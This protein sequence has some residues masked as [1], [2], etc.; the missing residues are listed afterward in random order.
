M[1]SLEHV[2]KGKKS[3]TRQILAPAVSRAIQLL[4]LLAEVGKPLSLSEL[5][6][7]LGIVKSSAF[8]LCS[9]L[10][11]GG[12][13]SRTGDGYQLGAHVMAFAHAYLKQTSLP[14][15]FLSR[16]AAHQ[17]LPQ[18]TLN[19]S[20][21]DGLDVVYML[22]RTGSL[23]LGIE[24]R[25][26]TR[27]P[28]F[29]AATGRAILSTLTAEHLEEKLAHFPRL[30]LTSKTETSLPKIRKLLS[31]AAKDGYS[32][33]DEEVR[34]GMLAYGAPVFGPQSTEAVAGVAV[35]LQRDSATA[36]VRK[37]AIAEILLL[38]ET[39]SRQLGAAV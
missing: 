14:Q 19:L 15:L 5:A 13:L 1:A 34:E 23:P 30:R 10:T 33:D 18:F 27:L 3:G 32:V 35:A 36:K 4:N 12:L 37:E 38:A 6:A 2:E 8:A 17:T 26:G 31:Q 16:L 24:I 22:S 39:L 29:Y 28:A 20:V 21:L 7:G 25:M 9:E 11:A